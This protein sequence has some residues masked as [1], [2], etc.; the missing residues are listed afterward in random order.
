MLTRLR[1][2]VGV[3]HELTFGPRVDFSSF[4]RK[5]TKSSN[6]RPFR[7]IYQSNAREPYNGA[8]Q[9]LETLNGPWISI[10]RVIRGLICM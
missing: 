2:K 3:D 1:S 8:I 7:S 10:A 5:S 4:C 9:G 6:M